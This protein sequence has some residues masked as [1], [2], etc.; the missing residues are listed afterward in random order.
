M[1][2]VSNIK[3]EP[4][5]MSEVNTTKRK[6]EDLEIEKIIKENKKMKQDAE[7]L[8]EKNEA[9]VRELEERVRCPVCLDIPL[10][11]PIH[12][13]PAGHCLCSSC[14]QGKASTCP[15]CR[16]KMGANT[17]L[18]AMSII[19]NIN[20][21]CRF[22]ECT[23]KIPLK[24]FE[25]HKT[26]CS[27]RL[28]TCPSVVCRKGVGYSKVADHVLEECE[29]SFVQEHKSYHN[30]IGSSVVKEYCIRNEH[31]PTKTFHVM[32]FFW[33]GKYFFFTN[34]KTE[35]FNRNMYVQMLGTKEECS[36]YRVAITLRNID[37]DENIS[38]TSQPFPM[39]MEEEDKK[40][41]GLTISERLM[42]KLVSPKKGK[43]E[44]SKFHIKL[45]F[46]ELPERN[47]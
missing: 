19:Q 5:D 17:S 47:I 36:K 46:Q 35:G 2:V 20:H 32:G 37:T 27:F 38:Y 7:D 9:L 41:G 33:S 34:V 18:L 21:Q 23:V 11:S 44:F 22:E 25:K 6:Y 16:V 10:T 24:D 29:Y 40:E 43:E 15:V 14:Y 12:S 4:A 30:P 39:E 45:D 26:T 42:K 31:L 28:V 1:E 8:R 3:E 13:C